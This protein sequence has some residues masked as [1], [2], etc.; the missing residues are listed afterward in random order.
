MT[1]KIYLV[2]PFLVLLQ[3]YHMLPPHTR[4][5]VRVGVIILLFHSLFNPPPLRVVDHQ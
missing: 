1:A 3:G 5:R 4:G 2:M